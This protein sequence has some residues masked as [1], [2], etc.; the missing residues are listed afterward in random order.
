MLRAMLRTTLHSK[1]GRVLLVSYLFVLLPACD[2]GCGRA[3]TESSERT[4]PGVPHGEGHTR[5]P[6]DP[7]TP[8]LTETNVAGEGGGV[9]LR[10]EPDGQAVP[11]RLANTGTARVSLGAA[12]T[13]EHEQGGRWSVVSGIDSLT[14]RPDCESAAPRCTTLAPGAELF[15]PAWLGTTGD[16]QC[17]CE[18]CARVL[19]GRYRFVVRSCDGARR[20]ESEPFTT[21]PR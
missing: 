17:L 11:I 6:S 21:A 8:L 5:D 18:A 20:I 1:R 12:V 9:T 16:A 3:R 10:G 4:T 2:G 19:P 7:A 15:P 14:L 13:V